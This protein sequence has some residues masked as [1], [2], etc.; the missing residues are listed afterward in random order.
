[1]S[2]GRFLCKLLSWR[3]KVKLE[4]FFMGH[5]IDIEFHLK[6]FKN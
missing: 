2:F 4:V 6:S 5:R 3:F 1:M